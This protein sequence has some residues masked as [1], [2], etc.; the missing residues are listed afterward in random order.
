MRTDPIEETTEANRVAAGSVARSR[1]L[2]GVRDTA[3]LRVSSLLPALVRLLSGSPTPPRSAGLA[4]ASEL[5]ARALGADRVGIYLPDPVAAAGMSP[6]P[7][8]PRHDVERFVLVAESGRRARTDAG[9]G[10]GELEA[11]EL[12]GADAAGRRLLAGRAARVLRPSPLRQLG[13]GPGALGTKGWSRIQATLQVPCPGPTGP[14]ALLA[15]EGAFLVAP[16]ARAIQAQLE[17][18]AALLAGFLER[19]RLAREL[20]ALRAERAHSERLATLGR[21]ACS[22]AHDLN[23]ILPVIVGHADLLELELGTA[24]TTP[25][26]HR[27]SRHSTRSASPPRAGRAS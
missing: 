9:D 14:V 16:E 22:V 2:V 7:T 3:E 21:V 5:L 24:R 10:E 1:A 17:A 23:N 13:A 25:A 15:F 4:Q 26:T 6:S 27:P 11:I 18:V 12:S 8:V 20:A 19:D